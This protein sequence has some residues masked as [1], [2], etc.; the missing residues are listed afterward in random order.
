MTK[1][2]YLG[3]I[4]GRQQA[5][6]QVYLQEELAKEKKEQAL[7]NIFA[8]TDIVNI[9]DAAKDVLISNPFG[10]KLGGVSVPL[11]KC[12]NYIKRRGY[13][14]GLRICSELI[15]GPEW[16]CK[17]TKTGAVF[18]HMQQP[19]NWDSEKFC[20]SGTKTPKNVDYTEHDMRDAFLSFMVRVVPPAAL[21]GIEPV[22]FDSLDRKSTRKLLATA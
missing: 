22:L 6:Q 8:H 10:I 3:M 12:G 1:E 7:A 13:I 11:S 21:T 2:K 15:G 5:L 17:R 14:I 18:Y 16:R 19:H 20:Y 4:V 9:W